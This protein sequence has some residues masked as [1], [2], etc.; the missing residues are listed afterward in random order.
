M[1]FSRQLA[2]VS[3][4][5]ACFFTAVACSDDEDKKATEGDAGEGGEGIAGTGGGSGGTE[6]PTAG[7]GGSAGSAGSAQA[8][9]G[10]EAGG[11]AGSAGEAGGGGAAGEAGAGGVSGEGGGGP[12]SGAGGMAGSPAETAQACLEQCDVDGDCT[13]PSSFHL[14]ACDQVT[15][16]CYTPQEICTESADCMPWRNVWASCA[17]QE[18][19][20]LFGAVCVAYAGKG[21][22]AYPA[23]DGMC[24]LPGEEVQELLQFGV[25]NPEL[26]AICAATSGRCNAGKCIYG[27]SDETIGCPEGGGNTCNP[28]T[29]LCECQDGTE[30]KS[31]VCGE[32]S[33]CVECVTNEHCPGGITGLDVCVAGKCGCSGKDVCPEPTANTTA[34]CE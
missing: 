1:A 25:E 34:V 33:R 22:C 3:I 10:G 13:D 32:S 12:D 27:C 18:E 7:S 5:G 26:V 23:L 17:E 21:Y 24:F 29:G 30:C 14:R 20:D 8:G 2:V 31:G 4:L 19:C 16:R 9:H 15:K 28:T 6:S 11:A